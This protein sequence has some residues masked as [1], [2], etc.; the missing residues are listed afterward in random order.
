MDNLERVKGHNPAKNVEIKVLEKVVSS[1]LRDNYGKKIDLH[2]LDVFTPLF[3]FQI[4]FE[5]LL[6]SIML[7]IKNLCQLIWYFSCKWHDP[8]RMVD[9]LFLTK[10]QVC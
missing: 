10:L 2:I 8:S 6:C 1:V 3:P 4:I 7:S 5:M 9:C